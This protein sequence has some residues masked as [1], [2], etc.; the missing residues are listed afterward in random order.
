[1]VPKQDRSW[2]SQCLNVPIREMGLIIPAAPSQGVGELK[3]MPVKPPTTWHTVGTQVIAE[4]VP[5]TKPGESTSR[6]EASEKA[7]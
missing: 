2:L 6:R 3:L 4:A 7:G 1:M 5:S